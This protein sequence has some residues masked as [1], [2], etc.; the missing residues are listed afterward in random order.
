MKRFLILISLFFFSISI[1]GNNR[2]S[3]LYVMK[4]LENG[5]LYFVLP[6]NIPS[7]TS[8]TRSVSV[9]IT[10][11]TCS[12]SVTVNMSVWKKT[13]IE[14]DSIIFRSDRNFVIHDYQTFFIEKD[15]KLWLHRYS[16]RMLFKDLKYLYSAPKSF[17]IQ[18][19]SKDQLMEYEYTSRLWSK[20]G[21]NI[22]QVL[23][24]IESN[25]KLFRRNNK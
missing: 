21:N 6:F 20:E 2:L 4:P 7:I 19:Y 8:K 15:E 23:R 10:S 16:I 18:V 1:I 22:C 13:E 25:K 12:D 24:I 9:D 5:H 11:L 17:R 3:D 14:T